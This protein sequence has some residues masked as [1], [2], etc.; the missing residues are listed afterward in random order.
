[1]KNKK[2]SNGAAFV[3]ILGIVFIV[4]KLFGVIEWSWWWVLSP[5][6]IPLALVLIVL[7]IAEL[8]VLLTLNK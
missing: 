7:V 1:M 6:W 4:C 2:N 8:Y 3:P 5:F